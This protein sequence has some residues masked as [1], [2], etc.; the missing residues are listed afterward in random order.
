VD[1]EFDT[2]QEELRATV[3]A[4]LAGLA[5]VAIAREVVEKN[6]PVDDLWARMVELDWPALT[7]PEVC[8]GLGRG[9][10]E[11]AVVIEELGRVLAPVPYLPTV[12]QFVPI[13]RE[14]G[15]AEQ[16]QRFLGAVA[17]GV[18]GTLAIAGPDGRYRITASSV[19][20]TATGDGWTLRGTKDAV[21]EGAR[22]DEVAVVVQTAGTDGAH[23]MAVFVVPGDDIAA[24]EVSTLDATRQLARLTFDGVSVAG[25]RLL[26]G[27]SGE[28]GLRRAI[29]EA[30]VALAFETLG[31]CQSIFDITLAYAKERHQFGVPIGSF[32]AMKHKLANMDVALERARATC[33][34]AAATIAENDERRSLAASMAKAA[35]G[36][37]QRLLAQEGI[38]CLGGIGF[39]WEHD[40]HLYVKRAKS[41]EPQFGSTRFHRERIADAIGL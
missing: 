2:D 24:D 11:L 5:P 15:S 30:T 22:S 36:D 6:R 13:V 10:L 23:R 38:Q 21:V 8:G 39:T 32:Q 37:C 9:F 14:L 16:Q 19:E 3:R 20:A 12:S 28:D 31:V 35:T 27:P 4:V 7:I 33:Y 34:F 18:T 25:D 1:L 29:E 41:S 40:M 26:A 17:R